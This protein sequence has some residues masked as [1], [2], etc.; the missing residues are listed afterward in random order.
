MK[1]TNHEGAFRRLM[2]EDGVAEALLREWLPPELTALF[3][4]P[5][6]LLPARFTSKK[7]RR[8][9]ADF[10]LRVPLRDD[11]LDVFVI[12]EHKAQ[13]DRFTPGQAGRYVMNQYSE[14]AKN[15]AGADRLRPVVVLIVYTGAAPWPA[16]KQFQDLIDVPPGLARYLPAFETVT[17]SLRDL[18][19]AAVAVDRRLK[20]GLLALKL[21]SVSHEE[22]STVVTEWL[23]GSR[24]DAAL[25]SLGFTYADEALRDEAHRLFET[26]VREYIEKEEPHMRTL[27]DHYREQYGVPARA[28]GRE[29]SK[30]D[31]I[32][33]VLL[34]RFTTL[35][36]GIEALIANT[37]VADLDVLLKRCATVE[38]PATLLPS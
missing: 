8:S 26:A 14:L 3:A 21:A 19:A 35:P 7:L 33:L 38:S 12:L 29:E 25:R 27:G 5:P 31:A 28:Q 4:G 17:L 16:P 13:P 10:L 6:E 11:F 36:E 18:P 30:R 34:A 23:R 24:G 2:Q 9:E 15:A 20:T 22:M 1:N 32:R 37:A